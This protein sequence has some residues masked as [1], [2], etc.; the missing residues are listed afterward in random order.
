MTE[1]EENTYYIVEIRYKD[2]S[3]VTDQILVKGAPSKDKAVWQGLR[4]CDPNFEVSFRE[5]QN[6]QGSPDY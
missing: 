3:I 2:I 4:S 1:S 6:N 5:V